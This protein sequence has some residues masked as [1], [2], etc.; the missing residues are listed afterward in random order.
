MS[1]LIGILHPNGR[2]ELIGDELPMHLA[3][4]IKLYAQPSRKPLSDEEIA[5]AFYTSTKVVDS[6]LA[7]F[8]E[9]FRQAE[10]HHGIDGNTSEIINNQEV[11]KS[12]KPMTDE[13]IEETCDTKEFDQIQGGMREAF[14]FGVRWAERH[15]GISGEDQ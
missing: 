13:E 14:Y 8:A 5:D 15:H 6:Q 4:P 9:G 2:L 11:D 7:A 1:E 12:R 3:F 10:K